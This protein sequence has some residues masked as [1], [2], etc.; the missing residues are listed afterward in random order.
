MFTVIVLRNYILL[1]W[2]NPLIKPVWS[3]WNLKGKADYF[4]HEWKLTESHLSNVQIASPGQFTTSFRQSLQ[5]MGWWKRIFPKWHTKPWKF[6]IVN[7]EGVSVFSSLNMEN[8]MACKNMQKQQSHMHPNAENSTACWFMPDLWSW[9]W[10]DKV[11][12]SSCN[13]DLWH[14][15]I[16]LQGVQIFLGKCFSI[17]WGDVFPFFASVSR[18]R[19]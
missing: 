8:G 10:H 3:V 15:F 4:Q 5:T 2:S 17:F 13:Q 12:L 16:L 7:I 14:E 1:M 19:I 9:E 18:I 11:T 6:G